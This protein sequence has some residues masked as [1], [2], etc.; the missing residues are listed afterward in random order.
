MRFTIRPTHVLIFAAS[1]SFILSCGL[2]P[3]VQHNDNDGDAHDYLGDKKLLEKIEMPQEMNENIVEDSPLEPSNEKNAKSAIENAP[4]LSPIVDV[5]LNITGALPGASFGDPFLSSLP[6]YCDP[7]QYPLHIINSIAIC[8]RIT[9]G[10]DPI[11]GYRIKNRVGFY[12]DDDDDDHGR[13]RRWYRRH[14]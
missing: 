4:S 7:R 10:Y 14:R 2:R 8:R 3:L 11:I 5:P 1:M 6:Y 9:G 12:D 13:K